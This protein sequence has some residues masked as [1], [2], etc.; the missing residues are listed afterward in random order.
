[1]VFLRSLQ[2]LEAGIEGVV[3]VPEHDIEAILEGLAKL[4]M[5]LPPAIL[6]VEGA[7]HV[8]GGVELED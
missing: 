1:M 8:D 5:F 7:T 3:V 4:L 2:E 6:H